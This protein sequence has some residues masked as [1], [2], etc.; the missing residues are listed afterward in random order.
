VSFGVLT[1][2]S[3]KML[4]L[5]VGALRSLV[6]IYSGFRGACRLYHRGDE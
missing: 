6:E 4:V 5:W 2:E 1:A 3:V